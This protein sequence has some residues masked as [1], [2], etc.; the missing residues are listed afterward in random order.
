[1]TT[2]FVRPLVL[3]WKSSLFLCAAFMGSGTLTS[4]AQSPPPLLIDSGN[5]SQ[6]R[7]S[8]TSTPGNIVLEE[9]DTLSVWRPFTQVPVLLNGQFSV[10]VDKAGF[11]SR[12]FR[13]HRIETGGLPP[14][15]ASVASPIPQGVATQLATATKFLY[16]GP[17]PIQTGVSPG[18]I[19]ARRA[20]VVRG[21]VKKR[22][23]TPLSGV[24]I[25]ILHHPELGQ[26]L[27]RADGMFDLV[28]NGGGLLI[29]NYEKSD[30]CPVQRQ[31]NVPWQ[32]Y[33]MAQEVVMIPMDPIATPIA[34]GLDSPMQVHQGS[35]QTDADGSRKATLLFT[36]GTCASLVMANGAIQSVSSLNVRATEITVGTNGPA[37][38]PAAL[39]PSS[40]YTY[41]AELSADEAIARGATSVQFDRPLPVYVENFLGFPVGTAVPT[42][43]YDRQKGQ[44]I[45]SVNGRVIKVLS[46]T[47]GV[48]DLDTDGDAAADG[49][50]TLTALG[51]STVERTCLATLYATGQTLW[52]VPIT[53]FSAW[54]H[55][56]PYGP[57]PDAVPP[58]PRIDKDPPIDKQDEE[59]KSIIG[60]QNQTLGE[61]LPIT[62]TPFRLHYQSERTPGR[63]DDFAL[64]I[65][66]SGTAIPASLQRMRVEVNVAGRLYQTTFAPA[67]NVNYTATW[68][69]KD[70]Y[71]RPLQGAQLAK[72]HV[73]YD[74][75]PQYY[76]VSS[77]FEN[78]FARA[79]AA[80]VAVS[81]SRGAST[82]TLTR[83]W[84][85]RLGTWDARGF[86]L[87]GWSLSIQHAYDTASRTLLLGDGRQRRADGLSTSVI[88]TAAGNGVGGFSGDGGPA[89]AAQLIGSSGIAIAPDGSLFIAELYR[90]RRVGPDGIITTIAGTGGPGFSGDGG[91]ATAASLGPLGGLAVAGDGSLYIADTDNSRIRRVGLDGII[92]TVA[93][94][95]VAGFSGDGGPATA[96]QL[97]SP[98]GI[99]VGP[100]GSVYVSVGDFPP[101][102]NR[103]RRVGPD[104]IIT[105]VAGNGSS[106]FSGDGGPAT[107]AELGIAQLPGFGPVGIAVGSDGSLYIS[108]LLNNRIRRVGPD[109]IIT[110]VAGDG[111]PGDVGLN[112]DG[113]PA[114]T[115]HLTAPLGIAMGPGGSLYI[116]EFL[117]NRT[118][119]VG[120]DGTITTV[121]GRGDIGGGGFSGDGG[122][123][124]AAQLNGPVGVAVGP[125]G[126]LYISDL[127][128]SRIRRVVSAL[129][130]HT[131]LS[132]FTLASEDGREVYVF[133]DTGRHLKTL[134]ALTG[135]VRYQLGYDAAGYLTSV[136][137]G[138]GNATTI[139][140]AGAMA[141]AIVAPGGQRTALSMSAEGWLVRAA[142]SAA[143][144]HAMN[145]TADGLL[146]RFID[147]L[148]NIHNF[149]YD[150]L[151][152]LIRDEDPAGGSTSLARTEQ[153]NGYTVVTTSALGRIRS[154]QVEQLPIGTIRRTV[155]QPDGVKTVTVTNTDGSE[156]TTSA[157]GSVTTIQYGPDPR[158]GML[159]PV[160]ESVTSENAGGLTRKVTTTRTTMLSDPTNLLSLANLTDTITDNGV[161]S[162][163]VYNGI[164]RLFTS[165]TAAGRSVTLTV[166]ALGRVT[167][168]QIAGLAPVGYAYDSRGLLSAVTEGFGATSRATSLMYNDGRDLTGIIDALGQTTNIAY[169]LAGRPVTK[170]LPDSRAIQYAYDAAG[171]AT[172]ITPPGRPAHLFAYT[173]IDQIS[174]Y[175]PPDVGGANRATQYTY[176][177]D[178]GLTR[179][180]SPDGQILDFGYDSGGGCNCGRLTT[181][182]LPTGVF[183]YAYDA[184]TG[185][186]TG[187]IAPGGAGLGYRYAGT[188]LTGVTWTGPVSGS[189]AYTYNNDFRVTTENVNGASSVSFAYASDGLLTGAGGL[190]LT[191]NAQNGLLTGTIIGGATDSYIYNTLAELTDYSVAYAGNEIYSARYDRD[192]IG[193]IT[194]KTETVA[195]TAA[196]CGFMYDA[197]GRLSGVT[198]NGT[199]V[200]TY[201]YD[202]NGNRTGGTGPNGP[203]SASY[204]AQDRLASHGATTYSYTASGKLL[205]KTAGGQSTGYQYDALGNLL[206]VTLPGGIAINYLIDGEDRR[207]GKKVN[208]A[209]VQAFLF[210]DSLRPVAELDGGNN[211]VSR[212]VFA[213]RSNSPSH[214]IKAGVT[215]R[216]ITDHLGSPRL[217]IDVATGTV[218][219]RMNY[220]E[221]GR[222]LSDT[223]PGFQPFGFAGGLYDRDTKLIR[224]G[225]RDYDPEIGRWTAKDPIAFAGEDTNLY[226]Y[227]ISDPVNLI[228]SNGLEGVPAGGTLW[229]KSK[230]TALVKEAKYTADR[231]QILQPGDEVKW[232]ERDRSTGLEKIEVK[233]SG[234]RVCKG[235]VHPS[236]LTPKAPSSQAI[237]HDGKPISPRAVAS[238]GA[239]TRT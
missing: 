165:T 196:T 28:V 87:G 141:T 104:G 80:G 17:N 127:A 226:G 150:V 201:T 200:R 22:D 239:A 59:C 95:G 229:I 126:S 227:V 131:T 23:N 186:L 27:S 125:D 147:P 9:T 73:H 32:D 106:G 142:N 57:P 117:S 25:S 21:S 144:A 194:Q 164:S 209:L 54:D 37:A 76:A 133:G 222:V 91:P 5:S 185:K 60:C 233:R 81:A 93:G 149:T 215:Y 128:N 224:F 53:H 64:N 134:D 11:S 166:D 152:R 99:A 58:P 84:T 56:W 86:E 212:F 169:D 172:A 35:M 71:G 199:T 46:I 100:D 96:A 198:T 145:S 193:R 108:E 187:I 161:V 50:A 1:M 202:S 89:T 168:E 20:A 42:G 2:R 66:V 197:A 113:G 178:G 116:S 132:N 63:K 157:D 103:I 68:D 79:E 16:T 102:D 184:P 44:W 69:G 223:S 83:T 119:R 180:T 219:Q 174:S 173:S 101:T 182:T 14:D 204:D 12:F 138:S 118:R 155:T 231:L 111:E 208:G 70:A 230:D 214:M 75:E 47:G 109:G 151:G 195:G 52:R 136:T 170:T 77:D 94:T 110:T 203:V 137:D 177:A 162:T 236:N 105:T 148:G 7:L 107:E 6:V 112:G 225:A 45:A 160:A 217:V 171:N 115:A 49:A 135:A 74:Y 31:I 15:P 34:L 67:P 38:M 4:L 13:L 218:A 19:D 29:V 176:N 154:Y 234:G 30:F 92:T 220:D 221:F 121:A 163:R 158:W 122:P 82:I 41:C 26:T 156:Q 39:P 124:L 62:G 211:V 205:S 61:S 206:N 238:S 175:T 210:Q 129:P 139:E 191:R 232:I 90:I 18:T 216:I 237:G 188:L 40:G 140:R 65:P 228:D 97:S 48:A 143:E 78:S 192:A 130:G 85:E 43:Y 24:T 159:A 179:L 114:T 120:P 189:I 153:A 33:V 88:T 190:A 36:P 235:Y 51:V 213:T 98:G 167:Q 3:L 207:I 55:N 10:M 181:L 8:W 146:Q 183:S 123:A 72:V